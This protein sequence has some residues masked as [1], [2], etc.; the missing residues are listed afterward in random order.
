EATMFVPAHAEASADI[1]E[2]VRYNRDKVQNIAE[3]ILSI[4]EEPV[5][6]EKIL[7]EV[8]K[9]YGLA[10]NFEQYA[11]VGST[12]RSYLSWMKDNGKLAVTFQDSMLLWQ[13]A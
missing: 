4:C 9:G 6:F 11:L 10:M 1:K 3:R 7:Q 13:R 5:C 12:V 2:L 8:F